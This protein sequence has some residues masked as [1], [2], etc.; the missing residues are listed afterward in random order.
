MMV[1]DA[2]RARVAQAYGTLYNYWLGYSVPAQFS[3]TV[4]SGIV[5]P[6]GRWLA[7]C[8]ADGHPALAIA[9]IDLHSKD[10]DINAATRYARPWRRS[11]RA[12]L[13]DERVPIGDPRSGS[14]TTF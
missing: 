4:P 8:R 1:D 2:P 6:G 13:Y 3:N 10:E 11:A 7:R 14:R 12:G 5:G 9:D